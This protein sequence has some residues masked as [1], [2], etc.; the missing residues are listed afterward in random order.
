MIIP[1]T[2][3]IILRPDALDEADE[4][5]KRALKL[6]LALPEVDKRTAASVDRGT[7]VMIGPTAFRDFGCE[8]P[9]APGM[10]ISYARHSGKWV[11][12]LDSTEYVAI[13]D[14]DVVG[15]FKE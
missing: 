15:I 5:R 7:V 13:N 2:H 11:T 1:V 3:K 4:D 9:L 14:E 8:C 10:R 6:G 12:D